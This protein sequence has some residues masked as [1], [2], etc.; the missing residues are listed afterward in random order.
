MAI[1]VGI[2]VGAGIFRTPA[3]VAANASSE[4]AA[5]LAWVLGGLISCVGALCYAELATTYPHAGGDYHFLT[6]AY[7]KRLSFLFA[8]ARLSVIQTG[9]IAL[10]A[11]VFGDYASELLSLGPN[12]AGLYAVLMVVGL[13]LLNITGV[14]QGTGAQ[15]V[16]TTLEVL[17]VVAVIAAGVSVIA[18]SGSSPTPAGNATPPSS[19][20]F[21]L[22][23]VFVLLTYGGWNEAAYVSAEL[24]DAKR[25]MAHAMLRS[26]LLVM[27]LYVLANWAYLS[28]L[29]LQGTAGS[30][31]VATDVMRRAMGGIGATVISV[32]VAVAAL[33]SANASVFTGARANYAWGLDVPRF[34]FLGRW[35]ERSGTPTGGLLVQGAVALLLVL[36][37]TLTRKGF[38]TIVEYTAP[39]FWFFFL[40]AGVALFVLR[41]RDPNAS[42]PFRVPLYP[43]TPL[44]FCMT[45]AY[46]LYS[47]LAYTGIGALVGA[48]VLGAGALMLF[49]FS[50][51]PGVRVHAGEIA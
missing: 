40:L 28:V 19:P 21:G 5:L 34:G 29:G 39:V 17:G 41:R 4:T 27:V 14:R 36:L 26:I 6:R 8:W 20:S 48:A 10:L 7:G 51:R 22:M 1:I 30:S 24:R 23:M 37:G 18:V 12:S 33:T 47:S 2:V 31:A 38:V 15:N 49:V 45:S 42:R 44:L 32:L 43:F 13:T 3:V 9:S 35:S 46:L 16:L 25:T 11:F 50:P